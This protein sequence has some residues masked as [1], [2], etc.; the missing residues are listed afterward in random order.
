VNARIND[1]VLD[2]ESRVVSVER[3]SAEAS[4]PAD[5]EA[6]TDQLIP[7]ERSLVPAFDADTQIALANP[8]IAQLR[9][10][11]AEIKDSE[12]DK[13]DVGTKDGEERIRK[14][15][16]RCVKLRTGTTAAYDSWNRPLLD[17]QKG[18]RA[19]VKQVADGIGPDEAALEAIIKT[20]DDAREAEKQRKIEEEQARISNLRAKINAIA[21]YPVAAVKQTSAE[22]DSVVRDL[23][24]RQINDDTFGEFVDEAEVLRSGTILQLNQLSAA[25]RQQEEE[26]ARVDAEKKRQQEAAAK[27]EAD[28]ALRAKIDGIKAKA[29]DAMGKTAKEIEAVQRAVKAL[30]PVAI[31]F[32][33]LFGEASTAYN[34]TVQMVDQALAAQTKL[35]EQQ[36]EQARVAAEQ[37]AEQERLD[38]AEKQR[39]AAEA[40]EAERLRVA[41]LPA[42]EDADTGTSPD[43]P[44]S[45]AALDTALA[46]ATPAQIDGFVEALAD[47]IA[48]LDAASAA[49]F[50]GIPVL[51]IET[52]PAQDAQA[53]REVAGEIG[54]DS[55]TDP[56]RRLME[57]H[58]HA[59]VDE[60][61]SD[62]VN[63][64]LLSDWPSGNDGELEALEILLHDDVQTALRARLAALRPATEGVPA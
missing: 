53:F 19:I 15:L 29:F 12:I 62:I 28:R 33:D 43:S 54:L 4:P 44:R 34:M 38:A 46:G 18:I 64:L 61:A 20:V 35:E 23:Q 30:Q 7:L 2:V 51:A 57:S 56:L 32:G 16:R 47:G 63:T 1:D 59:N 24:D 41:S 39:L 49:T 6:A 9:A 40:A 36:A 8:A 55:S 26:V 48:Q 50:A 13:I 10:L 37:K 14:L 5:S 52:V 31:E 11:K 22:I 21:Y 17:A 27:A 42:E 25:K 45:D 60:V 3:Q 58:G